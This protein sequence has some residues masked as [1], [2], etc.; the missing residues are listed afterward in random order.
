MSVAGKGTTMT[1]ERLLL[2][3]ALL[4]FTLA[5]APAGAR[6]RVIYAP[7]PPRVGMVVP[8][9]HLYM[10]TPGMRVRFAPPA[11]RVEVRP[12]APS[13]GHVWVPGYWAWHGERHVWLGGTWVLP[14]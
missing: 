4:S 12:Y 7:P 9:P 5:P 8:A 13:P 10:A 6:P 2:P 11:P 1:L 14:P 3:L